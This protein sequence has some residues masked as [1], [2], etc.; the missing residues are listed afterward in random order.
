MSFLAHENDV[1][2]NND[3]IIKTPDT[4]QKK[5]KHYNLYLHLITISC[6]VLHFV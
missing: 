5:S 2:T 6:N 3:D 1:I 4:Q